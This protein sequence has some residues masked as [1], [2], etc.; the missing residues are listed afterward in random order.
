MSENKLLPY[1]IVQKIIIQDNAVFLT[2]ADSAVR[3]RTFIKREDP[4][5][6]AAFRTGGLRGLLTAVIR[7]VYTGHYHL[8]AGSRITRAIRESVHA[9][10]LTQIHML[11][12]DAVVEQL[13]LMSERILTRPDYDPTEDAMALLQ[14]Q[15][16]GDLTVRV[17]LFG[18]VELENSRG[19]VVENRGRQPLSWALLKYLLAEP[20][21]EVS[22]NELL[23]IGL[24]PPS[25]DGGDEIGAARVRLRRLR[26]SLQPLGLDGTQGLVTFGADKYGINPKYQL[27]TDTE[28]FLSLAESVKQHPLHEQEALT[29]CIRALELFRG[30]FMEY[31]EDAPWVMEYRNYYHREFKALALDTLQRSAAVNDKRA[32]ALVSQRAAAIL[33][34]DRELHR[35][36]IRYLVEQG[37]DT[38]LMR[39]ITQLHRTGEAGWL[40]ALGL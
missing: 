14:P 37:Q 38:E 13:A 33:P 11:E 32:V 3:P 19:R 23:R 26:G 2:G 31:T 5:L 40:D 22:L 28:E 15:P 7:R 9:M 21:R 18:Q 17:R 35:T 10:S 27:A 39:H 1:E 12:E 30:P 34:E 6:T 36:I 16:H 24:W 25:K 8:R 4:A 20:G 29:Q